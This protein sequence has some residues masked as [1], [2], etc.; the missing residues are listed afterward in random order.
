M[1]FDLHLRREVTDRLRGVAEQM[2][3]WEHAPRLSADDKEEVHRRVCVF[4]H[5][6]SVPPLRFAGVDGSGDFPCL[7]Y[8][9]SFVYLSVAASACYETDT[10]C[11]LRE[12]DAQL[13]SIAEFTWLPGDDREAHRQWDV[14]FATLAGA[15]VVEVIEH[16]D[17]R[18]IKALVSGRACDVSALA[19]GLLR[20]KAS[21]TGN[22]GIQLRA[23]AELG[24][25]LRVL[26]GPK[27]PDLLAIDGTFSLPMVARDQHSLFHEHLKRLCAT[28]ARSAGVAFVAVSKSHGLPG[29]EEVERIAAEATGT[30]PGM[31]E[32]WYLRL[33]LPSEG[34]SLPLVDGRQ[35]PP[36]GSVTYLV[37]FHRTTPTLRIDVDQEYWR[38]HL[39]APGAEQRLFERLDYAGHDQRCYGYP[40]PIKAGHDRASLTEKERVALRKQLVDAAVTAGMSR[41]LFRSPSMA[42]GHE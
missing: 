31:A 34:W 5:T 10:L 1:R 17:Y 7:T 21:D 27:A 9:D 11:G 8:S 28:E 16:S 3:A 4:D 19:R 35:L 26:R 41:R 42:T 6:T 39:Q 14:A 29:V 38:D 32:H 37:R 40:Y 23:C 12:V 18:R 25:A 13:T 33:P 22:V 36:H 15:A 30:S 24:A 2:G 20:P